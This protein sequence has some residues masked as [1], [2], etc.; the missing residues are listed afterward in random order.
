MVRL[1]TNYEESLEESVTILNLPVS[2]DVVV[3]PCTTAYEFQ[4]LLFAFYETAAVGRN[5]KSVGVV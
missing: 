5:P 4:L 1:L 2:L 3:S